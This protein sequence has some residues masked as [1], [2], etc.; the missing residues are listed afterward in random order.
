MIW[1]LHVANCLILCS[2]LMRNI[3]VLRFLSIGGGVF[4]AVYFLSQDPPMTAPV[5]W[6]LVF[7]TVNIIQIV[8][9][10]LLNRKIP[11]SVEEVFL[12]DTYFQTLKSLE[13]RKLFEKCQLKTIE[14]G[15]AFTQTENDFGVLLEGEIYNP[16]R[17]L[18]KGRFLGVETYFGKQMSQDSWEV[19]ERSILLIWNQAEV[20]EW[21][22]VSSD[23]KNLLLSALSSDLLK[24]QI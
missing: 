14:M 21:S 22:Q 16:M 17:F 24:R 1:A 6:N 13:I 4:F 11:L 18:D 19:K 10:L 15:D 3:L 12:K 2:F 20:K 7:A 23:R 9:L 8:R 5:Q